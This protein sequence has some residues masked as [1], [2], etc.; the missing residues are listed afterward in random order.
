MSKKRITKVYTKTGDK[1]ETSLV[2]GKR[3][4]KA[5]KRVD[6]YGDV[7]ELNSF[8]GI[9]RTKTSEHELK[10]IIQVIQNDLFIIGGDLATSNDSEFKVPR[11]SL[12]MIGKLEH[13]IDDFLKE[14]GDLKEF[15]LPSGNEGGAYLHLART[16]CRRA[17]RKTALLMKTEEINENVL[18][19][20]NRLSDLLFVLA[21]VENKRSGFNEISVDF[22]VK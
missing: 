22:K 20:L 14:V 16:V 15:I 3:V 10:E 21:R 13:L 18:I 17:E 5:S 9:S 8:L 7:D 4:S 12:D 19:Y 2:G 6:A 11:V 1:G